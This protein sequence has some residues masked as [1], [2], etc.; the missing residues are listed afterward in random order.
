MRWFKS[1]FGSKSSEKT[2]RSNDLSDK[3]YLENPD[4][5]PFFNK[6]E[7]G[8]YIN[9]NDKPVNYISD[10]E[11]F[12]DKIKDESKDE[13]WKIADAYLKFLQKDYEGSS[14]VLNSIKTNDKNYQSQIQKMKMHEFIESLP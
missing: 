1:I 10:L 12:T 4:R 5:I 11:D 2:D 9:D 8:Y 14:E 13:S 7:Y 3:Q 6:P